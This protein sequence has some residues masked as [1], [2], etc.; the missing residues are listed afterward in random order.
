MNESVSTVFHR[1]AVPAL[2]GVLLGAGLLAGCTAGEIATRRGLEASTA[3][4][5]GTTYVLKA[6][7]NASVTAP[8][9]PRLAR[10]ADFF[11]NERQRLA[12]ESAAGGGEHIDTLAV[13]LDKPDHRALARWMQAHYVSLFSDRT[14]AVPR[15]LSRI[16][17]QAG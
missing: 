6:T 4:V 11:R 5:K 1:A 15:V 2:A 3:S 13:L 17:A 14:V 16:D 8:D 12:R 7:G 9:V 10:A